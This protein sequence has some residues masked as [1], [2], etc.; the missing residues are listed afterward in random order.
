MFT[1]THRINAS[2][3]GLI[4][5]CCAMG[6]FVYAQDDPIQAAQQALSSTGQPWYD[7][8]S[9]AIR[10]LKVPSTPGDTTRG[11]WRTSSRDW[12]WNWNPG[13]PSM[14]WIG[15]LFQGMAWVVLIGLLA[16][17]IY[18]LVKAYLNID[19]PLTGS[20]RKMLDGEQELSDEQRI[21]A[22][23]VNV[24]KKTGDFMAVAREYYEAGDY[25][26]AIVYLFSYR[27]I[28]LD[29]AGQIRLTKG[30][31]NRQYLKEVSNKSNEMRSILGQTIVAFEDV[32]FGKHTLTRERFEN[33]WKS[34]DQFQAMIQRGNV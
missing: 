31:T 11:G 26:N 16:L 34:N 29:R 4:V 33:C 17:V 15:D 32:F 9:D 18:A 12:D 21:E 30:K 10:T 28:Q 19:A 2:M 14:S 7:G 8:Q 23:P 25:A 6:N 22:L 20:A 3:L 5:S 13:A 24:R 27:L 1:K